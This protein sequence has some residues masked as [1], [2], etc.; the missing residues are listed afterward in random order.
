MSGRGRDD[1]DHD[2]DHDNN[3]P[4]QS[5]GQGQAQGN[6]QANLQGQLQG[7]A[8]LQ[9]QGQGQGQGQDQGQSQYANQTAVQGL[10]AESGNLNLNG[11]GNANGNW[12]GNENENDNKVDNDLDN[13]IDNGLDNKVDN[14]LD[15]KIDNS[16]D[17]KIE[18]TVENN[19]ETKVDVDV[20]VDLDLDASSFANPVIDLSGI[21]GIEDSLIMPDVVNQAM[22]NGNMFNID[23]VNN[24]VDNDHLS[25]PNV[26]F[27]GGEGGYDCHDPLSGGGFEMDAH[28][29][30]AT[31]TINGAMGALDHGSVG[32]SA[33]T[34][35]D[36]SAFNQT[37]TMG[38]N[39]QFNSQEITAGHDFTDSH[40]LG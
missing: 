25:N 39:I 28:V 33:D 32:V 5:Q 19:V 30:G 23:Q 9:G 6:L 18:N 26:T 14:D 3:D 21:H 2:R 13:K 12:N 10:Y 27:N 4:T 35:V 34:V 7:Q 16:L 37:I 38:A 36:Q 40:D 17:N 11:N 1:R 24:L 8:N 29:H 20:K 31:A 22:N 15:N